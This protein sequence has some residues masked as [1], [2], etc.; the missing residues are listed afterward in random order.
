METITSYALSRIRGT[1]PFTE[2]R[3]GRAGTYGPLAAERPMRFYIAELVKRGVLK[4]PADLDPHRELAGDRAI[5]YRRD[6]RQLNRRERKNTV[7]APVA[8]RD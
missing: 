6:R 5:F 2:R 4:S 7:C 1:A 8:G 3:R